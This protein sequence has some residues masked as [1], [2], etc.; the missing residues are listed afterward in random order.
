M[1]SEADV[2]V[3]DYGVGNIGS[4]SNM[5]Q[6]AGRSA[7]L[8]GDPDVV[9]N[10]RRLLLPGVGAFDHAVL[11]LRESG[12]VEPITRAVR[13]R[14]IP[15]LGVCLGMQLLLDSSEEGV[16]PGLGFIPGRVRRFPGE[17]DD[18]KL[19]VPH[20]GWNEVSVATDSPYLPGLGRGDRYYFVHSYF[21]D[22]TDERDILGLT[23]YGP[24]F[25]S[26]LQHDNIVAAQF[27]PEKSHRFGLRFLSD[28]A[29][30]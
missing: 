20:M 30:S 24:T 22:P 7:V 3:V 25:A 26:A 2:V 6:K 9:A 29:V 5:L 28:F 17:F 12:L 23:T 27:H 18:T 11:R 10:A 16:E 4:L 19:S 13:E 21:A 1:T 8:S 15:L 14:G